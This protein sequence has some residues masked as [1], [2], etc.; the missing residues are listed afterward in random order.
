[1][2]E[3]DLYIEEQYDISLFSHLVSNFKTLMLTH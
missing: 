3:F 2:T 1:V